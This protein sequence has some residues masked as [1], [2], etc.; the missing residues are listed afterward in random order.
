MGG[1]Y[2]VNFVMYVILL[3]TFLGLINMIFDL[4]GIAFIFEFL[5]LVG[6]LLT[7]LLGS[8]GIGSDSKWAWKLMKVF[9]AIVFLDILFIYAI[10]TKEISLL[11]HFLVI[12]AVGFFISS[13]SSK[14][15]VTSGEK[16]HEVVRKKFT[17]GKFI[18]SK[19]GTK[20]HSP[21][22][23]WGKRVLKKNAVWFNSKADAK[24][25]GYKADACIN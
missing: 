23:D 3:L 2:F 12:A 10:T 11:Y 15:D 4:K 14:Q 25:A 7:A 1:K 13:F 21:K 18:A 6:L 17:P 20:F 19:T 5:L 24:K 22:C 9:F 8:I 16:S